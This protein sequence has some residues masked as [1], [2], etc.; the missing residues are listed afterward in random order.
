MT[1]YGLDQNSQ[2]QSVASFLQAAN[3]QEEVAYRAGG[4]GH[5]KWIATIDKNNSGSGIGTGIGKNMNK[6]EWGLRQLAIRE[7]SIYI[8][9]TSKDRQAVK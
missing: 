8:Y 1:K 4:R 3:R 5:K 9:N 2:F 6:M 7:Y